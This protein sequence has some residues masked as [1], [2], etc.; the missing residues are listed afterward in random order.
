MDEKKKTNVGA[1]SMCRGMP[2]ALD[3]MNGD[4]LTF[5]IELREQGMGVTPKTVIMKA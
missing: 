3:S 1:K 2:P 5:I 4:L